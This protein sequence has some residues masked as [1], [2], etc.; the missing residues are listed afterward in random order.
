VGRGGRVEAAGTDVVA[1]RVHEGQGGGDEPVGREV[2][3]EGTCVAA[4]FEE[5]GDPVVRG[6]V[7]AGQGGGAELLSGGLGDGAVVVELGRLTC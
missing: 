7:G 4:A 1:A 6:L 5:C 2:R 3:P